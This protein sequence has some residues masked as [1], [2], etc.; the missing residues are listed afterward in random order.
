MGVT[1]IK[2]QR[3]EFG[4]QVLASVAAGW[5]TFISG[6]KL[7]GSLVHMAWVSPII[8][9]LLLCLTSPGAECEHPLRCARMQG[10]LSLLL[11]LL[12]L[13]S[14]ASCHRRHSGQGCCCWRGN[15]RHWKQLC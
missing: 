6:F 10:S 13:V 4:V 7:T 5:L 14:G 3:L 15:P 8:L 2:H 9:H 11:P 1:S 12:P